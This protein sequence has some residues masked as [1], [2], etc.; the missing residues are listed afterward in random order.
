[1]SRIVIENIQSEA[2]D[3]IVPVL[4]SA[5]NK[6]LNVLAKGSDGLRYPGR[7]LPRIKRHRYANGSSFLIYWSSDVCT[8]V[9]I[10]FSDLFNEYRWGAGHYGNGRVP[11]A[12]EV[13]KTI[14]ILVAMATFYATGEWASRKDGSIRTLKALA[15]AFD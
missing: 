5:T 9:G 14:S 4:I 6:I 12:E 11:T 8:P 2:R 15:K 13:E 1:M 7:I 10:S 3:E